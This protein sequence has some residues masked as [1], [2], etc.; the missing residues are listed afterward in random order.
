MDATYTGSQPK[1]APFGCWAPYSAL[2]VLV[3]RP[4]AG[5]S[6]GHAAG[7]PRQQSRRPLRQPSP[8]HPPSRRRL[9]GH[10]PRPLRP[11]RGR[12]SR[13]STRAT[14]TPAPLPG[15]AASF[16]AFEEQTGI[17]VDVQE[18]GH[19]DV[20]QRGQG[21]MLAGQGE[22]DLV[23]LHHW[24]APDLLQ[25]G[26]IEPLNSYMDNPDLPR[27]VV[28]LCEHASA[29]HR[30]GRQARPTVRSSR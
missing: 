17:T 28:R 23:M 14:A 30:Q 15:I 16:A 27:S 1:T 22:F 6:A 3:R 9:T 13:S 11:S 20:I 29:G 5:R 12:R 4:A 7:L 21:D 2:V 18:L 10:W 8:R 25:A 24:Q 26:V 19:G